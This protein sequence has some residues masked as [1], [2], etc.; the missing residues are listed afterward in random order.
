MRH[1]YPAKSPFYGV[2][3]TR[4]ELVTSAMRRRR[5]NIAVVRHRSEKR[6][7]KPDSRFVLP[8]VL[9]IVRV[10][11]RQTVVSCVGERCALEAALKKESQVYPT[12]EHVGLGVHARGSGQSGGRTTGLSNARCCMRISRASFYEFR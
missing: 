1:V 5:D 3:P 9:A 7:N 12:P 4:L 10:G 6:L 2:D 11:C 8:Q